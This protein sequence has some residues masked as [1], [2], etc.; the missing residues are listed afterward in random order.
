MKKINTLLFSFLLSSV[1]TIAAQQIESSNFFRPAQLWFDTDKRII[2]AHGGGIL[3]HDGTYY[4]FG[5]H[6]G[7]SSNRA[8][9]GITCYS[10]SDLYNWKFESVALPVSLENG[11]PLENGCI[12]ERP[13]VIF[14]KQ[15][16]LF[17]MYFHHEL[18]HKGYEAAMSGI[19]VSK[20]A[21]G[22]YTYVKSSR[23]N[24][25]YWPLNFSVAQ[26]ENNKNTNL[27]APWWTPDWL[28][29]VGEGLF[30]K[31]DFAGGQMSRDMTLFVDDNGKAYHIYSSEE[32]LTLHIAELTA[33]YQGYTGRYIRIDPAGHNEAP[34]IFKKDGK[35]YMIT[36]GCTG[37]EPNSARL[38]V[39]DSI[40]GNWKRFP[41][42]CVGKGA[43]LTFQSQST[44]ILP[45]HGK[46]NQFIFMADRWKPG[47]PIDGRYVWL[48]ITFEG[49][50]P[51]LKWLDKWSLD[52]Y[53]SMLPSPA[54]VSPMPG[55]KLIWHDEFSE[56]GALNPV[57]WN[58]ENGFVRNHEEQWYQP[59]NAFCA[60]GV[61]NIVAQ[62]ERK[63]NPDYKELV[64]DWR[65]ER[66]YIDYT[67]ASVN[68]SGKKEFK[69]GCI[70]VR[71]KIPTAK[72]AWPA[73]WTL[74]NGMEW[75]SNGEIDI[76]EF[77]H[78]KEEPYILANTAWGS[79][80]RWS[81][82]WN[83][84]KNPYIE[85]L[86]KD[87]NWAEK[88]HV[89]KLFWN[90][91]SICIYIDDTLVNETSLKNTKNGSLGKFRNPFRQPHYFLLNLAL[92]GDN[93]GEID[94]SAFPLFFQIDYVRV[95]QK[96]K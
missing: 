87:P 1:F 42:P 81:A 16:N 55:Y 17:V 74:G 56:N 59:Q 34:A 68:T 27:D 96:S 44:F 95:Y 58:F 94:D 25:E 48:P 79:E 85:F 29:A 54:V 43:D 88:F 33:D 23:V 52:E 28:S 39:A 93:G 69:Y 84:K 64:S 32:N 45:V 73:I 5:E 71:A 24:A 86:K 63:L 6:K 83:S 13:K 38:F 91:D 82:I 89:W 60:N 46:K 2:N 12:M 40:L 9:V 19:A 66:K 92:G 77:Y 26:R 31:R 10:S 90:K 76:M 35:Y 50:K 15:T 18:K 57:I 78:I 49:D 47:N 11:N 61:L 37:W 75:P 72:G 80:K 67:S 70:E 41:N 51:V 53:D 8:E 65:K 21:S 14:N 4:W 20:N 3:Y 36:S 62:K 7:E 30:V 22:P